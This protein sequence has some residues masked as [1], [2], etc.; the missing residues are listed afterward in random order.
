M[1]ELSTNS[2]RYEIPLYLFPQGNSSYK[3]GREFK[4]E[5]SNLEIPMPTD[6]EAKRIIY[7]YNTGTKVLKDITLSVTE[8]LE[9][10]VLFEKPDTLSPY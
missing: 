9:Q 6:S 10:Y 4:I 3:E 7:I 8:G 2:T 5:P 1:V